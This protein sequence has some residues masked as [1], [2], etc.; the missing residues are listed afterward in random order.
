MSAQAN[1]LPNRISKKTHHK[2]DWW[3]DP[4]GSVPAWPSKCETLEFKPQYH[5]KKKN[6]NEN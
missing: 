3:S 5:Q 2:V 1:H 4:S 6:L